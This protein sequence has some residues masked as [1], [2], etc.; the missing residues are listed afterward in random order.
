MHKNEV[1]DSMAD[2]G[3]SRFIEEFGVPN[4]EVKADLEWVIRQITEEAYEYAD[5]PF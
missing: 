1:I 4:E 2:K 5:A 3:V